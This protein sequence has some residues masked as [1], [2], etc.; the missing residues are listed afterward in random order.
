MPGHKMRHREDR[1]PNHYRNRNGK[2]GDK[3]LEKALF[4]FD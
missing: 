2:R 3:E 1:K 4:S